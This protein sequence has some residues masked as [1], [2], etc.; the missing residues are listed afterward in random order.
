MLNSNKGKFLLLYAS[1]FP[2]NGISRSI[3]VDTQRGEMYFIDNHLYEILGETRKKSWADICDEYDDS[4]R[5]M[6]DGY[7]K[8]LEAN[9]LCHWTDTPIFFPEI[10]LYW[11]SPAYITNAII[12][13]NEHSNHDWKDVFDQLIALGCRDVQLRFFN[14]IGTETVNSILLLID[15]SYMKSVEF[16]L[17]YNKVFTKQYLN[18]MIN[19]HVR[20]KFFT[21]FNA[22]KD[23]LFR[24]G[25]GSGMGHVIYVK[26][27]IESEQHCGI[28]NMAYFN[29]K[30]PRVFAEFMNHNSCLNRKVG[31]DVEG[32]IKNCPS[33]KVVY[34]NIKT[35]K[36]EEVLT[37]EFKRMWNI[38]KDQVEICKIC[39]FRYICSDC[40]A[41]VSNSENEL[42]KPKK[43]NYDPVSMEWK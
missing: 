34:G 24:K 25:N 33:M 16:I 5:V 29:L 36:I 23:E 9:E 40:R 14:S 41:H 30:E 2:V 21:F 18:L 27:K 13:S 20:I 12:D 42:S 6:L 31:I 28:V 1:C 26:E 37:P 15:D 32:N 3:I 35:V 43:C 7:V 39:E 19:E 10:D 22:P 11:D 4:S 8:F 38:T 17:P